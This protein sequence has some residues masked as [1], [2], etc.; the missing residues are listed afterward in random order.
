M[1]KIIIIVIGIVILLGSGFLYWNINSKYKNI[2]NINKDLENKLSIYINQNEELEEKVQ[3]MQ[4][5]V[6]YSKN[7]MCEYT[8]TFYYL[9]DYDYI[10][11]V[12]TSRFII[13]D[14]FQS[15]SPII[16]EIDTSKFDIDFKYNQNYEITFVTKIK[17]GISEKPSITNIVETDKKGLNQ[18]QESCLIIE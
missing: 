16:L 17:D 7:R 8:Q 13:V 10:G 5:K 4:E 6:D 11:N 2:L 12:P 3:N 14:S 1:K 15:F 9:G 18:I